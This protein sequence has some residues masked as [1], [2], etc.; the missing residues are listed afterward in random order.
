MQGLAVWGMGPHT[1]Q[2]LPLFY[3]EAKMLLAILTRSYDVQNLSGPF[4]WMLM[5]MIKPKTPVTIQ[6]KPR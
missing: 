2:G 3:Q 6:I 4:E 1:C 5:P